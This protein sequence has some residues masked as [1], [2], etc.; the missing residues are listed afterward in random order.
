METVLIIVIALIAGIILRNML[1]FA[2]NKN[3]KN[4]SPEEAS[5]FIRENRDAVILDVRT[6]GEFSRG[7]IPGAKLMPVDEISSRVGELEKYR[8]KPIFVYCASGHRSAS[9]IRVLLKNKFENIY[10]LK[11]GLSTWGYKLKQ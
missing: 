4:F 9:A 2:A 10:N 5:T 8:G 1:A 7:H 6:R 3:V 11:R